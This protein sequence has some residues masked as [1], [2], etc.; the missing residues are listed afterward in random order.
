MKEIVKNVWPNQKFVAKKKLVA[1]KKPVTKFVHK[2]GSQQ[3]LMNEK[4]SNEFKEELIMGNK[5]YSWK[6][7]LA[8]AYSKVRNVL[9]SIY[10]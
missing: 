10:T 7:N 3:N 6:S 8:D 9:V 1:K 2:K 4:Q 5:Q